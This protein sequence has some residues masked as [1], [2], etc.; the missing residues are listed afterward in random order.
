MGSTEEF[1]LA[2]VLRRYGPERYD[3]HRAHLNPQLPRMLHAIGFD[4]VYTSAEGAYLYD[5]EGRDYLDMLAGFGVYAL[6]RHHPVIRK[7]MHDVLDAG[8]ADLT[9]FDAP[10]LAGPLATRLL[11]HAPHLQ[12]VYFG[13]SGTEA[14]E[15][16]LKFARYFTGRGRIL[17][18]T[19][20]FHGLTTGS[21]SVNGA[22]DFR[23]GFGPLLPDTAIPLGD[24][25]ALHRE[26]R[27]GDVAGFLVEPVQ[28]KGVA[29]SPPGFLAEAHDLLRKHGALL[30]ADE[31]QCG[32]GR[33]GRFFG[34]Q[35][36]G[37]QPDL[38]ATAKAL[39]G[40]YVPVGATLGRED[41]FAKVYSSMDRVLV[42]DS[43]F[44]SN[45]QAMAAG[46]ATLH[47]LE[48]EDVIE[49]A[50]VVGSELTRRLTELMDRYE[51]LGEVRGRGLMIG[52]EFCRPETRRL[53]AHWRALQLARKG[54]FTQTVVHALFHRHRILTQVSGDHIEVIKLI[55]PLIIGEREVDRF[56]AAFTDVMDDAHEGLRLTR[57][58]GRS[59]LAGTR[60]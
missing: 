54:L 39:S 35:H 8:L 1:D 41:I 10:A 4:R 57:D 52:I 49:N 42:H 13:N 30:I 5:D 22:R 51:M 59:L 25:D 11:A 50:R 33:T 18:C 58:F 45:N 28:G 14:V 37:V 26:L 12:R 34:F 27:R 56:M 6:G 3:L 31:V 20:A 2:D 38:I 15:A 47:V 43:T 21:L 46:L 23:R 53:K 40:G 9:Q 16:A 36:D 17:Y 48:H 44:G 60:P 55:P 24:L 32:L 29:V 7:A 19:H